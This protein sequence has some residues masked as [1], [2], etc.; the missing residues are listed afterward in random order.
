MMTGALFSLLGLLYFSPR[1]A[2]G[3]RSIEDEL[4]IRRIRI[5]TEIAVPQKLVTATWRSTCTPAWIWVS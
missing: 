4:L 2:Q 3:Y 1:I 5:D